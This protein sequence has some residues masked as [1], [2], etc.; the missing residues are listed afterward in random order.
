MKD[1][2]FTYIID[3]NSNINEVCEAAI[4]QA[5]DGGLILVVVRGK[6]ITIK[7]MI[8][9]T[10]VAVFIEDTSEAVTF[11]NCNFES[12]DINVINEGSRILFTGCVFGG[13]GQFVKN[14]GYAVFE[15]CCFKCSKKENIII[16]G[17]DTKIAGKL[18]FAVIMESEIV[19]DEDDNMAFITDS[20][21]KVTLID[22]K[23]KG[24]DTNIVVWTKEMVNENTFAYYN[25]DY[26]CASEECGYELSE[27]GKNA[28]TIS[29]LLSETDGE[30][31]FVT[32]QK[33]ISFV[34]QGEP[35]ILELIYYPANAEFNYMVKKDSF[36]DVK[37]I[38]RK[39]NR[40]YIEV[41]AN[42]DS[43]E[44]I[45]GFI[46]IT[47]DNGIR[48]ECVAQIKPSVIEPPKFLS[49]PVII[50][51]DGR[52]YAEYELELNGREDQS[53]I[54]WYRVDNIDRTKLEAIK[55]FKKSNERDCRKI[56]VTRE[57]P[58]KEI[59]LTPFDVGRHLKVNIKPKH[60]R[61]NRGAG[62]NVQSRIIMASDIKSK[63]TV[64]NVKNQVLDPYYEAEPG[65]GTVCGAW[66]YKK[67]KG[68]RGYGMVTE[69]ADCSY[70]INGEDNQDNMMVYVI[71]DMENNAGEGF[72]AKG[73]Y[74][75]I[76][77]KYNSIKKIGYGIRYECID[78]NEHLAGFT[79]YK[80][81]GENAQPISDMIIGNYLHSDM[82]I[83][84][85]VA[86]NTLV[87]EITVPGFKEIITLAANIEGSPYSGMGIKNNMFLME[88][89][90]ISVRH[91]EMS[92]T[93]EL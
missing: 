77:I 70:Y 56:A 72:N 60:S 25:C 84:L 59:A 39:E 83:K 13:K 30:P 92:Y 49:T 48:S 65:Y 55:E 61:S 5:I 62:L 66:S 80:Y 32:T 63:N 75:E 38:E 69:S 33:N 85:D 50:I 3:N 52:A 78:V 88:N 71:L 57:V 41:T 35:E 26:I 2:E 37:E 17:A 46:T 67:L 16:T 53:D 40:V 87:A 14:T 89:N 23:I 28:Y 51:K 20:D 82:D 86:K 19:F 68:C 93:E 1:Y 9:G 91:I 73:E 58:C 7:D 34:A 15:K 47:S 12:N 10:N 79:L 76:Y 74:Q 29:N 54:S 8:F 11:E 22:T 81:D 36:I 6:H 18:T 44:N 27:E 64:I 90:R 45:Y 24:S 21:L 31:F 4:N 43:D 42:N